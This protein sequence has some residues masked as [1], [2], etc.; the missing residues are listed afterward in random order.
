[1]KNKEELP[2]C[3]VTINVIV[4][5]DLNHAIGYNNK[6]LFNCPNDEKY[7]QDK[8]SNSIVIMGKGTFESLG[9]KIM[10]HRLNIVVS[11]SLLPSFFLQ[12]KAD[13][14]LIF[15]D[16]ASVINYLNGTKPRRDIFVV[17]GESV[18]SWFL[19]ND[20][21][22]N[23]Y[24][25]VINKKAEHANRFFLPSLYESRFKKVAEET[26]TWPVDNVDTEVLEQKL[27]RI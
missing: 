13:Q 25:N 6:V 18:Y 20:Y 9:Y 12:Y 22:S 10:P 5:T 11:T 17:G 1:M 23:I 14:L 26:H 24:L 21:V 8:T 16:F 3:N 4:G 19:E 27:E 7:Y 15:S 2:Q